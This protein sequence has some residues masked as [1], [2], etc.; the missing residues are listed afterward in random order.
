MVRVIILSCLYTLEEGYLKQRSKLHWLDVG[1]QN[2]KAFYNAIRT[3]QAQNMIREIRREDGTTVTEHKDINQEAADF[4]SG[5]LNKCPDEYRGTTV[6][7]LQNL[8]DFRCNQDECSM[9][10]AEVT[11]EEIQKI[12]FAMPAN[13]SPGPADFPVSF[14]S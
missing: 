6:E 10:E 12:L 9:L 13:K 2:N 7:E 8:L 3:R 4:F 14:S 1:D 5:L 11:E